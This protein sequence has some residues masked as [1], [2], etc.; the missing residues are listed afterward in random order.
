MT[1]KYDFTPEPAA[2]VVLT[3]VFDGNTAKG[4]WSLREKATGNEAGTGTITVTKK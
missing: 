4:P 1:A 3:F 2:E